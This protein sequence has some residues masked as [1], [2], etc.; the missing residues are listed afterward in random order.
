MRSEH[1]PGVSVTVREDGRELCE[2]DTESQDEDKTASAYIQSIPGAN[3]TVNLTLDNTYP[4]ANHD[5]YTKLNLDGNTLQTQKM[6]R[7]KYRE[8]I[9]EGVAR[10]YGNE[11]TYHKLTFAELKTSKHI[12]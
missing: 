7:K 4:Y 3:F 8:I 11:S 9:Y 2:Y 1:L 5:V 10:G 6:Y 12:T